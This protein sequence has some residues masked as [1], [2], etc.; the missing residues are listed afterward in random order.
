VLGDIE[1]GV[2]HNKEKDLTA[3]CAKNPLS[4][5]RI[6]I[7][8]DTFC[9]LCENFAILAVKNSFDTPQGLFIIFIIIPNSNLT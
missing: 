2:C 8:S 3:K 5:Q 7:E 6:D 1:K 4:S 9:A